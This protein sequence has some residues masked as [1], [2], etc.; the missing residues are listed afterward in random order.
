[1]AACLKYYLQCGQSLYTINNT[2][3]CIILLLHI[4]Y[5]FNFYKEINSNTQN[6]IMMI[7]YIHLWILVLYYSYNAVTNHT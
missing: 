6:Y 1:M 3:K 5:Y 4:I 7:E 2:R